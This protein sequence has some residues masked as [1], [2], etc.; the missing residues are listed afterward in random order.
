MF[1]VFE[2]VGES[3]EGEEVLSRVDSMEVQN[4]EGIRLHTNSRKG[5]AF[6]SSRPICT[7]IFPRNVHMPKLSS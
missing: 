2:F 4:L 6:T 5:E 3:S 1:G 7:Y